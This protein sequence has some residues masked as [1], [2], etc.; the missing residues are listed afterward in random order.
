MVVS[1]IY[2]SDKF[3][4]DQ[5]SQLISFMTTIKSPEKEKLSVLYREL[6]IM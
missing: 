5:N 4:F 6:S 1:Q 3:L 2:T